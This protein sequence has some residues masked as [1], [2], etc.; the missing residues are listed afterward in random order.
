MIDSYTICFL[1]NGLS[2]GTAREAIRKL[3]EHELEFDPRYLDDP[4]AS[5]GQILEEEVV[6]DNLNTARFKYDEYTTF[7]VIVDL[8]ESSAWNSPEFEITIEID[9]TAGVENETEVIEARFDLFLDI[10]GDIVPIVT[11]EYCWG[12]LPQNHEVTSQCLPTGRPI[13]EHID[14]LSWIS[15]FGPSLMEDLG[16]RDRVLATPAARVEEFET[17]HV[18]VV[19]TDEFFDYD[20]GT[21]AVDRYLLDGIEL[22]ELET[23]TSDSD[24]EVSDETLSFDDPFRKFSP[25]D[26]GADVV[27]EK[28]AVGGDI[29]NDDLQLRRVTL[30][31]NGHLRDL[32]TNEFV[33][34]LYGPDGQIGTLP[35]DVTT[36]EELFPPLALNGVPVEFVRLSDP[37]G[38]NV[39]T[40]CM[41]LDADLDKFEFL[42]RLSTSVLADGYERDDIDSVENLLDSASALE[43]QDG[44]GQLL[45]QL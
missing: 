21:D 34:R 16:G 32:E 3:K 20:Y 41:A 11:P 40:K 29:S 22:T 39:V 12:M 24:P 19:K 43:N 38:E 28:D 9:G 44:I 31:E 7:S 25:G 35:S 23:D 17:G 13:V 37:D 18:L 2:D 30:D 15:V 14:T 36:E 33:R 45:Q 8:D 6:P 10:V 1:S 27:V 42:V 5:A 26:I 4:D